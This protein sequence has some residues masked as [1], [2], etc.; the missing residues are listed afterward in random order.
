MNNL[1]SDM[2]DSGLV[3]FLNDILVYLHTVNEHFTLLEKVVACFCQ[4]TF[5]YKLKKC[6]FLCNSTVFLGFDIMPEGM[7]ISDSKVQSL[8]KW[9]VPTIVKKIELFLVF[10][11][12]FC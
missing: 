6:S 1:F 4:C 3:V 12:Y 9:P 5:Y 8:N 2:L 7:H 10:V 11:Q